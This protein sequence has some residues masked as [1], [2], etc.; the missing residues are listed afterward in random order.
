M[1]HEVV[2]GAERRRRWSD[3]AKLGI[4]REVGVDGSSVS[5]VA[6]R[7]PFGEGLRLCFA[8]FLLGFY[9]LPG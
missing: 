2:L 5:D 8:L 7:I 9:V 3:E 4:L 6:R 1:G